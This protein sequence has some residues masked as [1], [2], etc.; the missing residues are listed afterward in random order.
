MKKL[1][2]ASMLLVLFAFSALAQ[3]TSLTGTVSDPSGSV[4]AGA[5]VDLESIETGAK[6]N[7]VTNSGGV[8]TFAQLAP[9]T[10]RLT[11]KNQGFAAKQFNEVRVLVNQPATLNVI[12]EVGAVTETVSVE[13]A[14]TQINTVDASLGNAFSTK[15]I[16]QLPFEARNVVGLL[17]LQ[18]GVTF[19]G[20][21]DDY[22][23][24]SVN[25]GRSDQ[26]N[27]TLDGVDVNNQQTRAAFTSVLRV[28]LDSVQEQ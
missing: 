2:L 22:R 17:T 23:S 7:S 18:P 28:T 20:D 9:G 25:G 11:V 15:P 10:Y 4:I 12:L 14:A 24:G 26:A 27:V 16:L 21:I 3:T 8:Y 19:N 13:A 6:R 5:S 1:L